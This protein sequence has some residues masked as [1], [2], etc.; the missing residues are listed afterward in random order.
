MHPVQGHKRTSKHEGQH[1]VYVKKE[2][3][4]KLI[5]DDSEL[6][7]INNVPAPLVVK[8]K[9]VPAMPIAEE[10]EVKQKQKEEDPTHLAQLEN[11]ALSLEIEKHHLQYGVANLNTTYDGGFPRVFK[12]DYLALKYRQEHE[13]EA[14]NSLEASRNIHSDYEENEIPVLGKCVLRTLD[15]VAGLAKIFNG[16]LTK[17]INSSIRPR[18]IPEHATGAIGSKLAALGRKITTLVHAT[19]P[20]N[21]HLTTIVEILE[22]VRPTNTRN[23]TPI[24]SR[25]VPTCEKVLLYKARITRTYVAGGFSKYIR[26]FKHGVSI[27]THVEEITFDLSHLRDVLST[28]YRGELDLA[29][30]KQTARHSIDRILGI[31]KVRLDENANQ[32]ILE[33]TARVAGELWLARKSARFH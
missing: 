1:F 27:V 9:G 17:I 3:V 11:K 20:A 28:D 18:R 7:K 30:A 21:T 29:R 23:D 22:Q 2:P 33:N 15:V 4:E 14:D 10:K 12:T 26:W 32:S 8:E 24:N 31:E 25:V 19:I 6:G 16:L 13:E 5:I